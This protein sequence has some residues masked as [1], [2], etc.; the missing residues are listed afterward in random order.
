MA[1]S[2][3]TDTVLGMDGLSN[4]RTCLESA[5]PPP[6]TC[7]EPAGTLAKYM[8]S[9]RLREQNLPEP[10]WNLPEPLQ[11]KSHRRL[12]GLLLKNLL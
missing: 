7:L 1:T 9:A 4:G 3:L 5:W 8:S 11:N 6:G 10:A 12:S 2:W